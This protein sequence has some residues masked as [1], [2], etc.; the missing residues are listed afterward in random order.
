VTQI[1]PDHRLEGDLP[2]IDER[3][4]RAIKGDHKAFEELFRINAP[5]IYGRLRRMLG[6]RS[7]LEDLVQ[8]V[9]LRA[10]RSL[11]SFR[12]QAPFGAWLRRICARVAYDEIRSRSRGIRLELVE[13]EATDLTTSR[14]ENRE[15]VRHL[16]RIID[17]LPAQN[18]TVLLLHDV[19]GYTAEEIRLV[20]GLKSVH[21]VR[22]R[23]RLA[24]AEL[25]RK[26]CGHP[27][28]SWLYQQ[29]AR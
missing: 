20:V 23:L 15:A 28:L 27:A 25:H 2:V 1:R 26:A 6:P 12:G 3:V 4:A 11:P 8:D 29:Q 24:R 14:P 21:T 5:W 7:N 22:S 9:F 13:S 19:E 16:T 18:R 10:Y 17:T